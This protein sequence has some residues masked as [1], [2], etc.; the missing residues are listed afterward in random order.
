V[1]ALLTALAMFLA[2][3]ISS[4]TYRD[5]AGLQVRF[6]GAV[7]KSSGQSRSLG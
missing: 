7:Y 5:T 1:P 3:F 4:T 2:V 6:V